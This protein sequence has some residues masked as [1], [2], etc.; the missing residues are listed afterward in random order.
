[1]RLNLAT[2]YGL[3]VL[4]Y[5][6]ARPDERARVEAMAETF[7]VSSHHLTKV[8]QRLS[9]AGFVTTHRGRSGG[10]VLERAPEEINLGDVIRALEADFALVE[11]FLE[12]GNSCCLSPACRLRGVIGEALDAF[13]GTFSKYTLADL[14]APGLGHL[15]A[16]SASPGEATRHG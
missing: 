11:C 3:R 13:M 8:V 6:L 16:L 1:M 15:L 7:A 10:I 2:D 14:Q 12:E 5:L 9:R 4:M